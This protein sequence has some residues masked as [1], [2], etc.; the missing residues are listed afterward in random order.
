M[1]FFHKTSRWYD[2]A[3]AFA[4]SERRC[5]CVIQRESDGFT[6]KT[7]RAFENALALM[8]GDKLSHK[9]GLRNNGKQILFVIVLVSIQLWFSIR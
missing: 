8:V 5:V 2:E 4:R 9:T 3:L 1:F 6:V 7:M